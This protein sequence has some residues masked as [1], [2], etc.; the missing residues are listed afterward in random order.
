MVEG[1]PR[2]FTLKKAHLTKLSIYIIVLEFS[3][4]M[5]SLCSAMPVCCCFAALKG[6]RSKTDVWA[7]MWEEPIYLVMGTIFRV[8]WFPVKFFYSY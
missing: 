2:N 5:I 7:D 8:V 3:T 1:T 4:L 6:E